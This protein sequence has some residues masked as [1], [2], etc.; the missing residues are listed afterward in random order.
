MPRF[1]LL[2]SLDT[3]P[4]PYDHE[5][6]DVQSRTSLEYRRNASNHTAGIYVIYHSTMCVTY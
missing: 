4:A 2:L 5:G 1:E 3:S 6:L